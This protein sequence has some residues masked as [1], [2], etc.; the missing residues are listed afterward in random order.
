MIGRAACPVAVMTALFTCGAANAQGTE[1]VYVGVG[2]GLSLLERQSTT[3]DVLM[4]TSSTVVAS[5]PVGFRGGAGV[6]A[7]VGYAFGNGFRIEADGNYLDSTQTHSS[8]ETKFG[9]FVNGAYDIDVGL[10]WAYPYVGLGVGYESVNWHA[11]MVGDSAGA[12]APFSVKGDAGNFAFQVIVG[13]AIPIDAVPGLAI[14]AEYRYIN[15][16]GSRGFNGVQTTSVTPATARVKTTGD[17]SHTMLVGMRYTF[18]APPASEPPVGGYVPPV[19]PAAA[20]PAP[21]RSYVVYFDWDSAS[22]DARARDLIA[23]AARASARIAY[24]RIE[25]SGHTDRT[26]TPQHNVELSKKRADAVADELVRW[27]IPRTA[28]EIHA[29]GDQN[30]AVPTAAGVREPKNRRVEIVYQ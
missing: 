13:V 18:A 19:P 22:L 7:T 21:A 8:D 10:G 23:D 26:G 2:A 24:T 17:A 5:K 25:V 11:I 6:V 14:T 16:P 4:G 20:Q 1:G 12:L 9:G 27:G 28:I 15:V 29:F 30:P 3:L